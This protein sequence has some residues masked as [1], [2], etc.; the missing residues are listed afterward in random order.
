MCLIGD[1]TDILRDLE[2]WLVWIGVMR[3]ISRLSMTRHQ[4]GIPYAYSRGRVRGP[5]QQG[6]TGLSSRDLAP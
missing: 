3:V 1:A 2:R 4:A 6:S 5:Q